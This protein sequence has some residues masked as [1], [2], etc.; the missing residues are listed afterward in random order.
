M[1]PNSPIAELLGAAPQRKPLSLGP[2]DVSFPRPRFV[3]TGTIQATPKTAASEI[4]RGIVGILKRVTT[5][6]RAHQLAERAMAPLQDAT[7]VGTVTGADAG[8]REFYHGLTKGDLRQ[9][10]IGAA[11][12][13]LSVAPMPGKRAAKRGI[14]ELLQDNSGAI[15]AWHGSPH[16]FDKF[17]WSPRTRGTGEG[18]QAF[19]SGLYF[20]ENPEVARGY[21][22]RLSKDVPGRLYEVNLRPESSD[23]LNRDLYLGEQSPKVQAAINEIPPNTW[24]WMGDELENY[25]MNPIEPGDMSYKGHHLVRALEKYAGEGEIAAHIPWDDPRQHVSEFFRQ[26]GLPGF[27]FLDQ[28]SR[29]SGLGNNA[30]GQTRN[31]VVFDDKLIDILNKF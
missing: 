13:A 12:F 19:G 10:G 24:E 31:Y 2:I 8:A 1:P 9:M 5:E 16:D 14:K 28:G 29:H 26:Q 15:R 7:P 6:R 27:T 17:E 22:G 25:G 11:T 3:P 20:A 21:Q 4:E 30:L 23:F 18:H